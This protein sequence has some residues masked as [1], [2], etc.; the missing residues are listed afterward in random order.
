M[1]PDLRYTLRT[2]LKNR[3]FATVAVL[4]LALG[5]GANTAI[6]SVV[7]A[8]LIRPLPYPRP[9]ELMAVY[10]SLPARPRQAPRPRSRV[11]PPTLRD[12]EVNSTFTG[13]A[14]YGSGDYILTGAGEPS[15]IPGA[16]VTSSFFQ[17]LQTTAAAGRLLTPEDDRPD[18]PRVV[19]I[20][21]ALW[22]SRFGEDPALVG[23]SIELNSERHTVVGIAQDGF[24]FP[25]AAQIW[26]SLALPA[27]ELADEQRLSFYL[28]AIG[29]LKPGV[30]REQAT[31]DLDSIAAGLA[32]K[33]PEIYRGRGATIEPLHESIVGD[34]KPALLILLGTVGFVLLIACANVA[35]L[36]LARAAGR[37]GEIAIRSALGATGGRIIRQLLTESLVLA[38]GG[39]LAGVLCALWARDAI[40]ALAPANVPRIDEVRIDPWVLA[41]AAA[42]AVGTAI[43]FGLAP[44][45]IAARRDVGDSLKAGR[46]GWAGHGRRRLRHGL[47]V[48]ELALSLSLLVGAGLLARTLWRLTS[49]DP[50]FQA[51]GVMTMEIVL[52]RAKYPDAATRVPFFDAVL[53]QLG[54]NPIVDAVGGAT[55]L[56]LSDTNMSFGFYRQEMVPA[57]DEP[58]SANFRGVTPGYFRALGVPLVRG[59]SFTTDDRLGSPPVI[60]INA[61]MADR[62]W[63]D[64]DPI[65]QRIAVTRG[66]KTVWREI[67]GIVGNVRHASLGA[68]PAPEMYMPYAHDAFPFLRIAVR[69]SER[70]EALAG[71]MRAAV[72]AVDRDQ[73]VSLVRSMDDVIGGSIASSRFNA[74]LIG[75]FAVLALALAAVGLYGV[76]VW[77]VTLRLREIGLRV[78]LGADRRQ[79]VQLVLGQALVLSAAGLALGLVL[80]RALTHLIAADL[81]ETTPMD[82]AT[83]AVVSAVLLLTTLGASYVPARR[84]L[85]VDPIQAL[86][87]E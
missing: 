73:P 83:L 33:F 62:Y 81:Y 69:S 49:V 4:T 3:G 1:L 19:V 2:L 41:F 21:H 64:T 11:A 80:A 29:R 22:R 35:N 47:V 70:P 31:A 43:V 26:A 78:A 14:A 23:K 44:A 84:A 36:L 27:S 42:L 10:E 45:I 13:L 71:A 50:G 79:I 74:I 53:E 46:A 9:A 24:A 18:Q 8:V 60:I 59:R 57:R 85:R 39:A 56:P 63:P 54:S 7:Y 68:R 86:R 28:E 25:G 82:P 72:W 87:A 6:F 40:V 75:A 48:L 52:P 77:S 20:G 12:W 67:V 37:E 32:T 66:M 30:S 17:V 55:N 51:D 15:R 58:L 65:G 5:I 16:D 34:V 76:M 61:T 38:A